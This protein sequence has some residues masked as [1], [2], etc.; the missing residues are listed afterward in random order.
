M[1]MRHR[2]N[3]LESQLQFPWSNFVGASTATLAAVG[4]VHLFDATPLILIPG[5]TAVFLAVGTALIRLRIKSV[6][7]HQIHTFESP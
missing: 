4:A 6:F 7:A 5:V 3:S 1:K 2:S